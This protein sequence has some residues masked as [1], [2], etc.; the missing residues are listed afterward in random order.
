MDWFVKA[1]KKYGNP[2]VYVH[3]I[4]GDYRIPLAPDEPMPERYKLQG[5]ERREFTSYLEHQKWCNDHNLVNKYAEG[6]S[7]EDDILG[8]NKWGY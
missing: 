5:Y 4:T 1:R 6:I 3:P 8:K 7:N 2:V